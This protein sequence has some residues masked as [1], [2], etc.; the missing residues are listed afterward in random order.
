MTG[1]E[2]LRADHAAAVLAFEVENR[3]YFASFVSDRGDAYFENFPDHFAALL[4]EQGAGVCA[5]HV[6]LQENG[7]VLGRFNL[8]DVADGTADLGYRVAQHATGRGLATAGVTQLCRLAASVYRLQALRAAVADAN[9]ASA[10]VLLKA[11][12]VAV[13]PAAPDQVG[14]R[15]GTSY[16]RDLA[17]RP[18]DT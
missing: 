11:G 5:F 15:S 8:Y 13:G 10:R 4:A 16:R 1:L 7:A 2:V 14:G 9:V 6:L 3:A 17:A 18:S 12:F